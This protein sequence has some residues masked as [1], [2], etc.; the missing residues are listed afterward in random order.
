[1]SD[2]LVPKRYQYTN[3]HAE[4]DK[5]TRVNKERRGMGGRDMRLS[6]SVSE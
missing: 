2:E 3:P 1:M 4:A 6:A 5:E